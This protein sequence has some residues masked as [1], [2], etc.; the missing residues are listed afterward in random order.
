MPFPSLVPALSFLNVPSETVDYRRHTP[1]AVVDGMVEGASWGAW[2]ALPQPYVVDHTD[3]QA[4]ASAPDGDRRLGRIVIYLIGA[5][6]L[7]AGGTLQGSNPP[8]GRGDQVR[9]GLNSQVFAVDSISA[10]DPRSGHREA[11]CLA[12]DGPPSA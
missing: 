2:T 12:V 9:L 3:D 11:V 4:R 1:G 5:P 10:Y 7:A 6:P 8:L